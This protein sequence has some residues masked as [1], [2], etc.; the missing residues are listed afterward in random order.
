MKCQPG[1]AG[2]L[3]ENLDVAL[4]VEGAGVADVA[5]V[6]DHVIDVGC[7]R[8]ADAF[9][10]DRERG[11]DR[12]ADDIERQCGRLDPMRADL[13][14]AAGVNPKSVRATKIVRRIE[15]EGDASGRIGPGFGDDL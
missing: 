8:P 12:A 7:F 9:E 15:L 1:R 6:V 13:L 2:R 4:A 10:M 3:E 14:P 5:V 11:A